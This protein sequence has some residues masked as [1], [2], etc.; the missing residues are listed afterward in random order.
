MSK[1]Q[2]REPSVGRRYR[3]FWVVAL[4]VSL[5]G[6]IP[7][8]AADDSMAFPRSVEQGSMVLGK[9]PPHSQVRFDGH[10]LK[11]TRYGT[12]VFGIERTAKKAAVVSIRLPDGRQK[13]VRI[14]VRARAWPI[15]KVDGV[16]PK[17]VSPPPVVKARI[18][19]EQE[20]VA[21]ARESS[22]DGLGFTQHFIWPVKGRISGRFGHQRIY[23][24]QPGSAHSGM[25]IAAARGTP[26]KAPASGRVVFADSDLYL[27]GGTLLIDHGHG[28]GSNFLHL[29]RLNAKVGDQVEQGQIIGR[30]GSTGRATGPHLH[31]GMTWYNT[32]IDP[33]LVLQ[34][35][36]RK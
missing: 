10:R 32:R 6:A 26:V 1:R 3:L 22:H 36:T 13:R 12:V 7:V 30:V 14:P 25:D 2:V 4:W 29:S 20:A 34:S 15:Q 8:L 28:I 18:K 27:T 11:P 31:W 19:R 16:P 5:G 24:G 9:V 33:L 17:T 35:G 21:K 23:N